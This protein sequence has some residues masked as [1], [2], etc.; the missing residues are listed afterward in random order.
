MYPLIYNCDLK[1]W[2]KKLKKKL[3]KK[4]EIGTLKFWKPWICRKTFLTLSSA[5]IAQERFWNW[6]EFIHTS[7]FE[8]QQLQNICW[9]LWF[10]NQK[11][12]SEAM[13]RY[14]WKSW[15]RKY[16]EF[17]FF[18][19]LFDSQ[20]DENVFLQSTSLEMFL[21]L[22]LPFFCVYWFA[23]SMALFFLKMDFR[24]LKYHFEIF[25]A[26]GFLFD[27]SAWKWRILARGFLFDHPLKMT[28]SG[29]GIFVWRPSVSWIL[30]AAQARV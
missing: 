19:I 26:R 11:K 2:K 17:E 28:N 3:K 12:N 29:S 10:R 14:F 7:E 25:S 8:I 6:L 5:H 13:K 1:T 23:T 20:L 21:L 18:W 30:A 9:Q 24:G 22:E 27:P 16:F 4:V 15:I